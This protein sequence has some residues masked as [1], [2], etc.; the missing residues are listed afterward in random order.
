MSASRPGKA[1]SGVSDPDVPAAPRSE[2]LPGVPARPGRP[3]RRGPAARRGGW[4]VGRVLAL[5]AGTVLALV[6][7]ALLAGS[8]ALLWADLQG[9]YVSTG[10][11]TYA[12]GGYAL[13]SDPVSLHGVWSW[14]SLLAGEVRIRVT[15]TSP[16]KPVFV[17]IGPA[18]DVTRY[19]SGV[20]HLTVTA[21]GDQDG[22]RYPGTTVPAAPAHAVD[23][24]AQVQGT[25]SQTLRWTTRTGDW[26]VVVMNPDGSA[27]IA[28]R[29]DVG[30]SSP[31]LP[32]LAGELLAASVMAGL[33][34][35]ALILIPV[36]LARARR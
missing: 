32:W 22:V 16:A 24:S 31:A 23:W 4:T 17:A 28:V 3:A 29:T 19:L 1:G 7:V 11:A 21:F 2:R 33:P 25:G 6:S 13:A 9:G 34:A 5:V 14:F 20:S 15:T 30:A 27:G 10:S 18:A 36:R 35:A 26:M 12:T 8:G